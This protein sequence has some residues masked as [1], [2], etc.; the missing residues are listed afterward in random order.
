MEF[1]EGTLTLAAE[2]QELSIVQ[3]AGKIK[4]ILQ[5]AWRG[6]GG[7]VKLTRRGGLYRIAQGFNPGCAVKRGL[8]CKRHQTLARL[9][10]S[11]SHLSELTVL[12][13]HF[14]GASF[15]AADPGL[16]YIT[17]AAR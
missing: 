11:T 9:V 1:L 13:R 5:C 6:E 16:F 2:K 10:K 15:G 14:Q 7:S 3:T 4:L 8:P 12:V 17:T